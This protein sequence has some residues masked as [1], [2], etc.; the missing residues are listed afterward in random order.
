M[1]RRARH[2]NRHWQ[3]RTRN[4]IKTS[5]VNCVLL[6]TPVVT[7]LDD[8]VHT[9]LEFYPAGLYYKYSGLPPK[10]VFM[11]NISLFSN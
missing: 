4:M 3:P 9:T 1:N 10:E 8:A 7:G 2:H 5:K 6:R 11:C